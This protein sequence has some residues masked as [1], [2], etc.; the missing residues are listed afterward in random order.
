M[1]ARSRGGTNEASNLVDCCR[2][3]IAQKKIKTIEEYREYK[4]GTTSLGRLHKALEWFESDHALPEFD[5]AVVRDARR[6]LS[7]RPTHQFA[8]EKAR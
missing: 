3:C 6:E 4:I 1:L 5:H 8:F 2:P 7:P